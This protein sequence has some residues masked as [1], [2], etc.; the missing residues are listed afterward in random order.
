MV[1]DN[2]EEAQSPQK[3]VLRFFFFQSAQAVSSSLPLA[4][5][6]P[7]CHESHE[8]RNGLIRREN[9]RKNLRIAVSGSATP[10]ATDAVESGVG[11]W[12]TV[13]LAK[14]SF[15]EYLKIRREPVDFIPE[16]PTLDVLFQRPHCRHRPGL[17]LAGTVGGGG[18]APGFE[19]SF[20]NDRASIHDTVGPHGSRMGKAPGQFSRDNLQQAA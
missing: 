10:L 4:V 9:F 16:S 8:G 1:D 6:S 11:R 13:R 20:A 7:P 12:Q 3:Q 5:W 18:R 17:L 14:L 2:D 19:R 15:Y